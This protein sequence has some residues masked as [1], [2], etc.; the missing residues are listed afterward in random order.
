MTTIKPTQSTQITIKPST[1][2]PATTKTS[3]TRAPPSGDCE[4]VLLK[5]PYPEKM[6]YDGIY[7][8]TGEMNDGYPVWKHEDQ[9]KWLF[10][11]PVLSNDF[12]SF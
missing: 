7:I 9:E 8:K 3:S 1:T 10:L 2:K 12:N 4:Q 6:D 5:G 11:G